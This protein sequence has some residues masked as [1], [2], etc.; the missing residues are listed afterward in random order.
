MGWNN[1]HQSADNRA[2][3]A[4]ENRGVLAPLIIPGLL[5]VLL[6]R[7][8]GGTCGVSRVVN[9]IGGSDL[10][11]SVWSAQAC[12]AR[13][14][15]QRAA[16]GLPPENGGISAWVW[17]LASLTVVG[18]ALGL[19]H[20]ARRRATLANST[21][22][23][24]PT[25]AGP[26][27]TWLAQ[28]ESGR[29]YRRHFIGADRLQRR[30]ANL[31]TAAI[32][33]WS[34]SIGAL[35]LLE[36]I[37]ALTWKVYACAFTLSTLVTTTWLVDQRLARGVQT[38]IQTDPRSMSIERT[39]KAT[40]RAQRRI[41]LS[42]GR[43]L[44]T[45]YDQ[46]YYAA[47]TQSSNE[48]LFAYMTEEESI[49][50]ETANGAAMAGAWTTL[51][52][53]DR[54]SWG[55]HRARLVHAVQPGQGHPN[56]QPHKVLLGA[57]GKGKSTFIVA[58]IASQLLLG[59][60]VVYISNKS[61]N[62]APTADI[63]VGLEEVLGTETMSGLKKICWPHTPMAGTPAFE[64]SR[65]ITT[66]STDAKTFK[67]L[68][69][70]AAGK[71]PA[72]EGGSAHYVQLAEA[73][74]DRVLAWGHLVVHGGFATMR[75]LFDVDTLDRCLQARL[76]DLKILIEAEQKRIA[77]P[78]LIEPRVEP[79]ETLLEACKRERRRA[80]DD[81]SWI[82][83]L[84]DD[85]RPNGQAS[86]IEQT[87]RTLKSNLNSFNDAC[88]NVVLT[89]NTGFWF[90]DHYD[91]II[92]EAPETEAIC[93]FITDSALRWAQK[94]SV[95]DRPVALYIDEL[96]TLEHK[97][98]EIDATGVGRQIT[99]TV[100][101]ARSKGVALTLIAQSLETAGER[102]ITG[103]VN[104][105]SNLLIM[106]SD[107][108]RLSNWVIG[109]TR[110]RYDINTR[111]NDQGEHSFGGDMVSGIDVDLVKGLQVGEVLA[112]HGG[113][114]AVLSP[115]YPL[116]DYAKERREAFRTNVMN[117]IATFGTCPADATVTRALTY[118]AEISM[119]CTDCGA[120][121]IHIDAVACRRCGGR[122]LVMTAVGTPTNL[123][124]PPHAAEEAAL[125][126]RQNLAA[127]SANSTTSQV[128]TSTST[129][130]VNGDNLDDGGPVSLF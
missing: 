73:W 53:A 106:G 36:M 40:Q 11:H 104:A 125:R 101:T 89:H 97:H 81:L 122:S 38:V 88:P 116:T 19:R 22:F 57:S 55:S 34:A 21:T 50:S 29:R 72:A 28:A 87:S 67:D 15:V 126:F 35:V 27:S 6:L 7:T 99:A 78:D 10:D 70:T 17:L 66:G 83:S 117:L 52:K 61:S 71:D 13:A 110:S 76:E 47:V 85:K 120:L 65:I 107:D 51:D 48:N 45:R 128:A 112:I 46:P 118:H 8:I 98:G 18:V 75:E 86:V 69:L 24:L 82:G 84:R 31:K 9:R 58:D 113:H 16:D 59:T 26:V 5:I 63:L 114:W 105:G 91:L 14:N 23:G 100:S 109:L 25:K 115:A 39:I 20:L 60:K 77:R 56:Q 94:N 1:E 93:T 90:D 30:Q 43:N 79:G 102:S 123:Q 74:L 129:T 127:I 103:W 130:N 111:L 96:A 37:T 12:L 33:T 44:L 95:A 80:K 108:V 121:R 3:D 124:L 2:H 41:L 42:D 32:W 68:M 62:G 92:I 64:L 49:V 4:S 54:R 119:R